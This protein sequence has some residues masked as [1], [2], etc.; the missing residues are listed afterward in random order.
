MK[1]IISILLI[2]NLLIF[3][4]YKTAYALNKTKLIWGLI[5]VGA[6][7]GMACYGFKEKETKINI[8]DP[9][10]NISNWYWTKEQII[11]WWTDGYGTVKNTG[12]VKLD[13]IKIYITYYDVSGKMIVNDYTYLDVHWLDPL[14]KGATDSWDTFT[15]CGNIEP[16]SANIKTTY[17]YEKEYII[18][19][20]KRNPNLGCIGIG[21]IGVGAILLASYNKDYQ[22]L[23]RRGSIQIEPIVRNNYTGVRLCKIF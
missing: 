3:S 17:K 2:A 8:S 13:D 7:I 22:Q 12:N 11:S 18:K 23:H 9:E 10:L 19:K 15:S 1:K 20:E 16:H 5:F 21:S 14:S 6:G 4:S